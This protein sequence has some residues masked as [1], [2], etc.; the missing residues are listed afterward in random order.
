LTTFLRNDSMKLRLSQLR[1]II[2]E[3]VAS[4]EPRDEDDP[5]PRGYSHGDGETLMLDKE[6]MEKSD[7]ENVKRYLTAMG[8]MRA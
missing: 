7:R 3:A 4:V 5:I 1:Y 8:I 6:G 2:S